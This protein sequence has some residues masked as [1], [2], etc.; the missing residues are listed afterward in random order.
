MA[1]DFDFDPEEMKSR[2]PVPVVQN[3]WTRLE[4]RLRTVARQCIPQIAAPEQSEFD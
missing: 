4:G 1:S 3:S 2:F